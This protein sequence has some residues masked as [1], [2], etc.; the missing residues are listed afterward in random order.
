MEA[1]FEGGN[2]VFDGSTSHF[3]SNKIVLKE[4]FKHSYKNTDVINESRGWKGGAVAEETSLAAAVTSDT[5]D[6]ALDGGAATTVTVDSIVA[7]LDNA[8]I[9]AALE[10]DINDDLTGS[11]AVTVEWTGTEYRI[12]S[13]TGT[14]S[15]AIDLSNIG[16]NLEFLNLAGTGATSSWIGNDTSV[17]ANATGQNF[18]V[19]TDLSLIHI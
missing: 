6:V 9:A 10:T 16:A 13:N 8:G 4:T 5:I 18:T 3:G 11:D 12:M 7:G 1:F 2:N 19:T 17:L 15:G 14:S